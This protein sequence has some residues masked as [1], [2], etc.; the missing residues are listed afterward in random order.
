ML[1]TD[2]NCSLQMKK[3]AYGSENF[4]HKFDQSTILFI[5]MVGI[6]NSEF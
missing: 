5:A 6:I 4:I 1:S 2:K 3:L